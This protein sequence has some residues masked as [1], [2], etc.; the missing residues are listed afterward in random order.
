MYVLD[1]EPDH[2][3]DF[4]EDHPTKNEIFS[5]ISLWWTYVD[6]SK[7]VSEQEF[8]SMTVEKKDALWMGCGFEDNQ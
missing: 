4:C 5:D 1:Y 8:N 2:E 3:E 6:P 7:L